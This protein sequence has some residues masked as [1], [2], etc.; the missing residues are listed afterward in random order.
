MLQQYDWPGN[1]RELENITR[2]AL[3]L[4]KN[5]VIAP[6]D[7]FTKFETPS[8]RE[9]ELKPGQQFLSGATFRPDKYG[10]IT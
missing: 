9:L 10:G 4:C 1:V 5:P 8:T 2:R 7:L 3:A 6:T